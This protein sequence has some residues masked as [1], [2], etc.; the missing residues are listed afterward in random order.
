M[1]INTV[2]RV[3]SSIRSIVNIAISE[4]G[5]DCNNG[6]SKTYFPQDNNS[7][8]RKPLPLNVIKE[9]GGILIILLLL[10]T[11]IRHNSVKN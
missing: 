6:F 8:T 11:I 2:K 1:N 5:L 7:K 3:F 10:V 9:G 4:E